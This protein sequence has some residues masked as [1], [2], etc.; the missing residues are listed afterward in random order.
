MKYFSLLIILC[1]SF[2]SHTL[3]AQ[4]KRYVKPVASGSGNGSSWS[5]ASADLQG[6][7]NLS[8]PND[9][10]WVAKGTYRPTQVVGYNAA[11][12]AYTDDRHKN[13]F[14]NYG[15]KLYGSFLG[16]ESSI[17]QRK[18]AVN[19]TILSGDLLGN[20]AGF[21]NNNDNAYHVMLAMQQG[22]IVIDGFT[23]TGGN[24]TGLPATYLNDDPFFTEIPADGAA[25]YINGT[26]HSIV[27]C[28][29]RY[30]LATGKGGAVCN[31]GFTDNGFIT[32]SIFV[33]NQADEGSAIHIGEGWHSQQN[34]IFNC[35]F[36][37]NVANTAT[38][39]GTINA[40]N[41]S[42]TNCILWG[43]TGSGDHIFLCSTYFS[44][45]QGHTDPNWGVVSLDPMFT[46]P[47]DP[48][49]ADNILGTSDDGIIPQCGPAIGTGKNIT[50]VSK[51]IRDQIRVQN[52]TIDMGA[53]ETSL[54]HPVPGVNIRMF[55]NNLIQSEDA[56]AGPGFCEGKT[57]GF[58]TDVTGNGGTYQWKRNGV[59]VGT[60]S[61]QWTTTT[62]DNG[63]VVTL[64]YS[65]LAGCAPA[66][67][68][69]AST[70]PLLVSEGTP[71]RPPAIFGPTNACAY[72]NGPF[73]EYKINKLPHA[74]AYHWTV[75]NNPGM[76]VT[77]PNGLGVNDT[78]IR[79]TF[80]ASFTTGQVSVFGESLC[81]YGA[82][83]YLNITKA[84]PLTPAAITG[85]K[86]P[87]P[88][89]QS[90]ANPQG[91]ALTYSINKVANASSYIWAVPTGATITSH[92]GGAG[93]NDTVITVVYSSSF[94]SGN[95]T[96]QSSSFCGTS[97]ARALS[98]SRKVSNT[99]GTITGPT[100]VCAFMQSPSNPTGT[101]VDYTI[102][103]VL[104]ATYYTWTIPVGASVIHPAGTG[105]ND[106]IIRVTY[107]NGFTGGV[108]TVKSNT[109]CN[110]SAAKS[111]SI[112]YKLPYTPGSI[113]ASAATACPQRRI[114]YSIA[115]LPSYATSVQWIV[116]PGGMIISGQGTLSVVVEFAGPTSV[117]DTIRVI[118]INDCGT[119][120]QRKLKVAALTGSCRS[121]GKTNEQTVPP[122]ITKAT[123]ALTTNPIEQNITV[124]PNPSQQ[125]FELLT[126]GYDPGMPVNMQVT[127][128][129][130][131]TIEAKQ[132]IQNNQ[133]IKIGEA[134]KPGIYFATFIQAGKKKIVRLVKL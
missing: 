69:Q 12:V 48:D 28:V 126:T 56:Q 120:T 130:G 50:S 89:M 125:Y 88:Y 52:G 122:A 61:S 91:T 93:F 113:T 2:L 4:T 95:I 16:S 33:N 123:A 124:K 11:H 55:G 82:N 63:D 74:L 35:T 60:N 34:N 18:L 127:D 43:N 106:T 131:R 70:G 20:D 112:I 8:A 49:G 85:I 103:K 45:I 21:S 128:A 24:T 15:V 59:N 17:G 19:K 30:N 53:Y 40:S 84:N 64:T 116:P 86:D 9:E 90:P 108:I 47:A 36:F 97:T 23:I 111:L 26:D 98:I 110:T 31:F 81:A 66:S 44:D 134:Y 32:N 114:T 105:V 78:V 79:V 3:P 96:V 13:F 25:V 65:A 46:N 71:P 94:V 7:I 37:N 58:Y 104:Y 133:T 72:I 107:S 54:I 75:L 29:F 73:V 100:S 83:R 10:V 121:A 115:S 62:M 129:A 102:R 92:P 6:M 80:N 99:P 41:G 22:S 39:A 5:N 119:S 117:T 109:S 1:T 132:N 87:C 76:T 42:L 38:V 67:I 27:N 118:G 68:V 101:A 57:M 51:D 14:L 77:H